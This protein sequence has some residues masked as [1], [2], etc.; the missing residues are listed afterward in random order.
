[1]LNQLVVS[2]YI[3]GVLASGIVLLKLVRGL[4]STGSWS[5]SPRTNYSCT[6]N[7]DMNSQSGS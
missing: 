6:V 1:M 7:S 3:F 4:V 2:L 5:V